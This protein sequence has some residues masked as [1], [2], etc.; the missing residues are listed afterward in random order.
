MAT[1]GLVLAGLSATTAPSTASAATAAGSPPASAPLTQ[2]QAR[3]RALA[4]GKPVQVDAATTDHSTLTA[5]PDGSFT[6]TQ[7][8]MPVRKW[9]GSGWEKLD[10]TLKRNPDGSITTTATTSGLTLSP[11]GTAPLATMVDRGRTLALTLPLTLPAPV[12]SGPTATYGNVL[13]GVDLVATATAQGA[14]SEV[15]VVKNATAAANPRLK[16]L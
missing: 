3:A 5:N 12:L 13:P 14:F 10:P 15:L 7:T 11:G 2:G 6:L 4:T 9:T 1:A 16:T 8:L